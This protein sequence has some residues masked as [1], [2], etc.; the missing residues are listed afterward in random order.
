[1]ND[2]LTYP[3]RRPGMDHDRY[4]WSI[5]DERPRVEWPGGA[6]LA[7]WVLVSLE[8]FRFD[9]DAKP[10]R[11]FGA[12]TKEYPDYR[13]WT[14][15]DYGNRVGVFRVTDVLERY[16]IRATAPVNAEICER[17]PFLLEEAGRLGWEV[18]GHGV[19]A[20]DVI[21]PAME[22]EA[23]RRLIG[24][25]LGILRAASGQPV[26][27]W[28]SPS[29]SESRRTPDL[30]AEHGVEYLCDWVNDDLPYPFRA[31]GSTIHALP[32]SYE[33]NDVTAIW[34]LHHPAPDFGRQIVDAFEL[35]YAE[36]RERGGRVMSISLHPW[37]I[38]QPHRI[39]HLDRALAR[40]ADREGVWKATGSEILD[41]FAGQSS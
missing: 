27:G 36:S 8:H 22:E 26:R 25:S 5:L 37:L 18:I 15:K 41:A 20:S 29:M 28:L 24:E 1:M 17:Y 7:L 23:E 39:V 12:P 3:Y 11:A 6:H 35:L 19:N 4:D 14:Q 40:I 9:A 13:E 2:Y 31:A 38:G 21:H 16:G 10:F 33:L 32:C 30:L 34:N